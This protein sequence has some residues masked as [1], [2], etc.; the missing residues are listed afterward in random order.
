MIEKRRKSTFERK[1]MLDDERDNCCNGKLRANVAV[2]LS[3][4]PYIIERR[5][6]HLHRCIYLCGNSHF[7]LPRGRVLCAEELRFLILCLPL[8]SNQTIKC[9]S[10]ARFSRDIQHEIERFELIRLDL[11]SFIITPAEP[12]HLGAQPMLSNADL[13]STAS[14][15]RPTDN[16]HWYD[17]SMETCI[18]HDP[19]ELREI[20]NDE[21]LREIDIN[22]VGDEFFLFSPRHTMDDE[23]SD[24]LIT[25][26]DEHLTDSPESGKRV[27][28]MDSQT[29][30]AFDDFHCSSSEDPFGFDQHHS[31]SIMITNLDDIIVDDGQ[32]NSI[33]RF[34]HRNYRRPIQEDVLYEVEHENSFSDH[35]Q[36]TSSIVPT[37]DPAVSSNA[38]HRLS[39]LTRSF[40]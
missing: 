9:V 5:L 29:S 17:G 15:S 14:S 8:V 21:N 1:V 11:D 36:N 2:I 33:D 19:S 12:N 37:D 13:S 32:D 39:L 24:S 30:R 27:F 25:E 16:A 38:P 40:Y 10:F 18:Q 34:L 35:S 7:S 28:T 3:L 31:S 22:A 20:P 6:S 26:H 23:Q 4:A